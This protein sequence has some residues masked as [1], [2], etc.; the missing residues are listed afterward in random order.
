MPPFESV[1]STGKVV[2]LTDQPFELMTHGTLETRY[3]TVDFDPVLLAE[4]GVGG[5]QVTS[6]ETTAAHLLN[7]FDR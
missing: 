2:Q 6:T 4:G 1:L 3:F 5:V 7:A